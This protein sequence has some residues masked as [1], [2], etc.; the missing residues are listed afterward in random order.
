M[1][2][3]CSEGN[4]TFMRT[5]NSLKN[6]IIV[7][8]SHCLTI[9]IGLISQA[10]FIKILGSEYL[11]LNSLFSNIIS[12]LAI[13][14]LG[15]GSAIIF[16]MYKPIAEE[17]VKKINSLMLFYKKSYHVI[18]IIVL[19]IGLLIIPFI[20]YVV[21]IDSITVNINI[22]IVYLFFLIDTVFSYFFS[23]N[24]SILYADQRNYIIVIIH[25]FSTI[26]LNIVQL[27]LL[28]I[29]KNYYL[30]LVI[31]IIMRL[32]ENIIITFIANKKYPF[33]SNHA[34]KIDKVT[35]ADILKKIKALFFHKIG[36]F[37]V[38]G[39]DNI[40]ISKYLGL[41]AVGLY[42]NYYLIINSVQTLFTQAFS[43]ITA[44]IGNLLATENRDKQFDIFKK[45]RF[46]NFWISAFSCT[47]VLVIIDSFISIWIGKE[48]LL[49]N[50][51]LIVL[52]INLY[53]KLMRN[54]YMS[55]KEAAGI[56]YED[57][58]VPVIESALNIIF[59]IIFV[60]KFGL[61]GVFMGTLVS[62]LALW[63]F[64]F[65]KFVYKKIFNRNYI[66]YFLETFGYIV[67][68]LFIVGTS[69]F[70]AKTVHF[71]NNIYEFIKNCI[72]SVLI[73]NF[74]IIIIYFKFGSFKY[75]VNLIFNK[76]RR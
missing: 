16:H 76:F 33:L 15:I 68:G 46:I 47:S 70:L 11:G 69:Y 58:F 25:I 74:L 54:S 1:N 18:G 60:K 67:S 13:A 32:L 44:S 31:R 51:V 37:I 24:R 50:F 75:C 34:D 65:P 43:S 72:V 12:M 17:D 42:S 64:S 35:E 57:R 29:F 30:Y 48:Y 52:V 38:L 22:Y 45:V 73:P 55:F 4:G 59:S 26:I 56:C 49:P 40:I 7:M 19:L 36:G 14:E 5:K 61:A 10:L 2:I 9:A 28:F 41:V 20:P 3:E 6:M 66:N 8:I 27:S 62:G 71:D 39:T 23:Y 21:D 53:Q 63:C